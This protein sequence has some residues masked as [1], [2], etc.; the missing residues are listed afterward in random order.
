MKGQEDKK[1]FKRSWKMSIVQGTFPVSNQRRSESSS[2]KIKNKEGEAIKTRQ[3]IT[4]VFA[5]FYEDLYEG[6]EGY[7][8]EGMDSR[9]EDDKT[10][11]IQHNS[12]S[13][14]TQNEIQDAIN[15]Q[16]SNGI[17]AE[18]LKNCSDDT[19]AR[20]RQSSTKLRSRRT[21]HQKAG[22]R[23]GYWSYTRK[24]T[25]K[26]QVITGQFVACQ[27]YTICLPPHCTHVSLHPCTKSY[28]P[29]KVGF[30]PTTVLKT[31]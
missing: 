26:M 19:K 18:Q 11:P 20:S 22:E 17:R 28:L 21:S 25:E 14:F 10:V 24:V 30:G 16:D 5:K 8:E 2:P 23:F 31:S 12:I 9:T 6:E 3:G 4:N 27:Y 13:E 7:T 15:R 1:K 29:T